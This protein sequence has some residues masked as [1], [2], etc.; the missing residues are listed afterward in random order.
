MPPFVVPSSA[1]VIVETALHLARQGTPVFPVNPDKVPACP[2]GFHDASCDPARVARLFMRAPCADRIGMPTGAATMIAVVDVDLI[3]GMYWLGANA[4]RLPATRVHRTP[5]GGHHLFFLC[6]PGL[7]CSTSRIAAGIDI[8]AEGGCITIWGPGYSVLDGSPIAAFPRFVLNLLASLERRT[9]RHRRRTQERLRAAG[10]GNEE[11]LLSFIAASRCG[12][13]NRR[14][15][16]AAVTAGREGGSGDALIAAAMATG[17]GSIEA[18]NTVKSG[19][20]AAYAAREA[21]S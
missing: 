1:D 21:R 13:R 20:H 18:R 10:G 2:H 3:S 8:K 7:R 9:A 6:P 14:L 11:A 5:R 17:L 16:W 19:M 4:S 15:F 12:E